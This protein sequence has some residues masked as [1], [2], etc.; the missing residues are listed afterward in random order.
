MSILSIDKVQIIS[1]IGINHDGSLS[2]A[3][4]MIRVSAECGVDYAK[5]QLLKTDEMY[6]TKA[7]KYKNDSGTF[8]IQEVV[9]ASELGQ[10]W[11]PE[12][13]SECDQHGIQFLTTVYDFIGLEEILKYNP[14]ALKVASYEIQFIPLFKRLGELEIPIIFSCAAA[15]LGDIEAALDAYGN[16]A[17]T[18]L[19]HCNGKYPADPDMVNLNVMRTLQ[20][21]FPDCVPGFSDH[22]EDPVAAP[23]A[24]TVLGAR[25]IEKHFTL[26]KNMPGPDHSFAVN[27]EGLASL[28]KEVRIAEKRLKNDETIEVDEVILGSTAKKVHEKE[29]YL[30]KFA[31][32]RIHAK[33]DIKGGETF[34]PE[35][36]G[37]FRSGQQEEGM[38]PREWEK[39]IGL[40]SPKDFEA[41][42]PITLKRLL[43]L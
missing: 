11:L 34:T 23:V 7:G 22:T 41:G 39:L 9:K 29:G 8:D 27:P 24:A 20:L 1:E 25:I 18:C 31:F 33:T 38:H 6:T 19:M 30:R 5:F 10:D 28:V 43:N 15:N 3:K 32:R 13:I 35:N 36:L 40:P 42:T 4:E 17:N 26:D 12:L 37:I 2:Q 21:A 14:H 16:P